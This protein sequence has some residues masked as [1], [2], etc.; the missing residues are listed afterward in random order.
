MP[1]L[2]LPE[3]STALQPL[4]HWQHRGN[5][6]HREYKF[7]DFITAFG[8]MTSMALYSQESGHHPE[9][10]NT[11]NRIT[12]D[13]TTHDDGGITQKDLDWATKAE[14]LI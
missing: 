2:S 14:T 1:Q 4:P 13:L 7:P 8:F 6:L 12:V 10:S 11:Y 5:K 9:W 3:L